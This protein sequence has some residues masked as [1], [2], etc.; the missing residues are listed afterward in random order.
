MGRR[1]GGGPAAMAATSQ[2]GCST[3][4]KRPAAGATQRKRPASSKSEPPAAT[5]IRYRGPL[6]VVY[7]TS[8]CKTE[9]DEPGK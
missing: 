7:H 3:T 2:F 9:S 5:A 4:V 6:E 8:Y 1:P